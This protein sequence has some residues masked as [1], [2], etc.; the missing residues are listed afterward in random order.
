MR[1]KIASPLNS[2][3]VLKLNMRK[4]EL[5]VLITFTVSVSSCL[6]PKRINKWVASHYGANI[7]SLPKIKNDYLSITSDLITTDEQPSSGTKQTRGFLPLIFYWQFDYVNTCR[8]NSK[9]PI[10]TFSSA[11]Q[12]YANTKG[13]KQKL[14][15]QKIELVVD[16]IPDVFE[17]HDKE[18]IVWLVYGVS[19][20]AVSFQPDNKEMIVTYKIVKDNTETKKGTVTIPNTVKTTG[21]QFLQTGK[22]AT[23]QYLDQYDETVKLMSK[24]VI[25]QI[26][27]EL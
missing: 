23:A 24:K 18:H 2:L 6:G 9:I 12:S 19:W 17:L 5:L 21:L 15:G 22:K 3:E 20:S 11:V 25:D 14:N 16:K 27:A 26:I 7:N 13:L 1:C 10:S 8:L 4:R